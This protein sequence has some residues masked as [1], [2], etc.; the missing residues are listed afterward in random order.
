MTTTVPVRVWASRPMVLLAVSTGLS[1]VLFGLDAAVWAVPPPVSWALIVLTSLFY[2][3]VTWQASRADHVPAAARSFWRLAACALALIGTAMVFRAVLAVTHVGLFEAAADVVHGCGVVVMLTA[4]F[5][6]PIAGRTRSGRVALWLDIVILMTSAV[7]FLAHFA[8]LRILSLGDAGAADVVITSALFGAGLLGVFLAVKVTLTGSDSLSRGAVRMIGVS[9]VAGGLGTA[10]S[11]ALS[12][13]REMNSFLLSIPLAGFTIALA[14][15]QQLSDST[16]AQSAIATR[17]RPFSVLPYLAVGAV[18]LLLVYVVATDQPD[19][20]LVVVGAVLLTAIVAGRQLRAFRENVRLTDEVRGSEARFRLLVQNANDI[21]VITEADGA[22]RYISPAV[23]RVLG[24]DP[25][26]LI[27]TSLADHTHPDDLP[28][29]R[30]GLR[31]LMATEGATMTLEA[32]CRHADGS[33][34]WLEFV[35]T[36]LLHEPSIRGRVSNVRDVSETR[37]VQDKLSHEATHDALTG[38]ANRVLYG[39]RVAASVDGAEPVSIVLID[40]DDFKIVNDTLGHAVG[41]ALLVAVAERLRAGVRPEDTVA[42]LGGDEFAL[43][44]PGLAADAV[45]RVVVRI[46]ESLLVPVEADGQLLSV[47]ASFGVTTGG[48]GDDPGE[49]LRQADIAMYEAKD[50]GKGGHQHFR[51]GMEARGSD[52]RRLIDA[53]TTAIDDDQLILHYQPVVSLPDGRTTGFEALVRWRHPAD[54]LIGPGA[55]IAAAEESG[56]IVPLG[57]WVL[58]RAARQAAD[59]GEQAGSIS[60]NV[61]GRQLQV[62][63]F[64]DEVAKALR[65]S[66][67]PA[68]RLILEITETTVVGGGATRTNLDGIRAQ[69][70]R[71]SLDDFGTGSSTLTTVAGLSVDQIKLDRSFVDSD[72]IARAVLLL[73]QGMNAEAVAEGVETP[74]QADRLHELGYRRAQGFLFGRPAPSD[75]YG[76]TRA[77]VGGP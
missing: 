40:L 25:A 48:P 31:T 53:L 36:N 34:R 38:L 46:C 44:L 56:L 52:R 41:D 60:V 14:A 43:L 32:R 16:A 68:R 30:D 61:S 73:A 45:D 58:N 63:G 72:V 69:G 17:A 33:W 70:V 11:T 21:T 64:A 49:L 19:R 12:H 2:V 29:L 37:T 77:R 57:R 27:G 8:I 59:W 18:D 3:P 15:R 23:T 9:A 67:L 6:L 22:L 26:G 55:F 66:G 75:E 4:M 47:R 76:L 24:Y 35:T 54:G 51:T 74:A 20:L 50:R 5:R 62:A 39:R 71:L 1:V 42:R 13:D 28:A 65:T 10:I 7:V